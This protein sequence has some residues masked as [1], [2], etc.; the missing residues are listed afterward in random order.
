MKV[1]GLDVAT[2][3]GYAVLENKSQ[4]ITKGLIS[5]DTDKEHRNR[6]KDFRKRVLSLVKEHKPDLIILEAVYSGPNPVTTAYLNYLRGI[7]LECLPLKYEV[8]TEVLSK[9]K[10]GVLGVGKG[11]VKK[12][13]VFEWVV[14]KHQLYDYKFSKHNDITDAIFLAEWGLKLYIDSN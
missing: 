1:L 2:N 6:F 3:T 5:L 8:R 7:V 13:E 11:T 10:K 12:K 4:I 14:E 9:V